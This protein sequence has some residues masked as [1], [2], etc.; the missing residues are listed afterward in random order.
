MWEDDRIWLPSLLDDEPFHG[1]F[2]FD[3]DSMVDYEMLP[4]ALPSDGAVVRR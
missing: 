2:L 3:D 4:Y 1:R